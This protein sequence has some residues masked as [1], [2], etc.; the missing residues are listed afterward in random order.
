M[1]RFEQLLAGARAM[2]EHFLS[3]PLAANM[4]VLL[5]LLGVWYANF[6]G[7]STHAVLPYAESAARAAGLPAAAGMESNGKAWIAT[8]RNSTTSPRR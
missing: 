2:D 7:A 8:D 4:P 6:L 3:A 1:D 5:A